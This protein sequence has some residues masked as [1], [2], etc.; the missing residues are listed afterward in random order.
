MVYTA[1][2]KDGSATCLMEGPG[3]PRTGDGKPYTDEMKELTGAYE[4]V[5]IIEADSWEDANI[6]YHE[7]QG[8]ERYQSME[9]DRG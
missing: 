1:W 9:A 2:G 6:L 4:L 7:M 8:W 3:P 5:W